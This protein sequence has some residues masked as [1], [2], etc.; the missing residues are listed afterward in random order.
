MNAAEQGATHGE[1]ERGEEERVERGDHGGEQQ[2]SE[3]I[4]S[5]D[6]ALRVNDETM[7]LLNDEKMRLSNEKCRLIEQQQH[8]EHMRLMIGNFVSMRNAYKV[9]EAVCLSITTNKLGYAMV[10]DEETNATKQKKPTKPTNGQRD[11][12]ETKEIVETNPIVLTGQIELPDLPNAK[13]V[14]QFVSS[15]DAAYLREQHG[16]LRRSCYAIYDFP[17]IRNGVDLRNDFD[18][19]A[20]EEDSIDEIVLKVCALAH[21]FVSSLSFANSMCIHDRARPSWSAVP[22]FVK[23]RRF[24]IGSTTPQCKMWQQCRWTLKITTRKS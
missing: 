19:I 16:D 3:R 13:Y 20:R 8:D 12:Y 5:I 4:R 11:E 10:F 2:R 1:E 22:T 18:R 6:E 23:S 14:L 15:A 9:L 24:W 21:V 17:F 7:R